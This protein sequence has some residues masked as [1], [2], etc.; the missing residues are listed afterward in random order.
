VHAIPYKA[1]QILSGIIESWSVL[2]RSPL[3][4]PVSLVAPSEGEGSD[5]EA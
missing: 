4:L 2:K 3:A 1:T 5:T